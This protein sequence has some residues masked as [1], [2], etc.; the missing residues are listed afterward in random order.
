MAIEGANKMAE[1]AATKTP[2]TK[3]I[4]YVGHKE[5]VQSTEGGAPRRFARGK[6]VTVPTAIADKLLKQPEKFQPASAPWDPKNAGKPY[7]VPKEK[8]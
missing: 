6:I 8:K 4:K 5:E 7:V 1:P 3:D 2:T